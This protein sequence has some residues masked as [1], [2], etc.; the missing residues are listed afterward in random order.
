MSD[1]I[2]MFGKRLAKVINLVR[3]EYEDTS[4]ESQIKHAKILKDRLAR[5]RKKANAKI[6]RDNFMRSKK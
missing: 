2:D 4:L 1:V 6:L 5:E 3:E